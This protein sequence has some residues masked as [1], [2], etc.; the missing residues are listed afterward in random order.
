[1]SSDCERSGVWLSHRERKD[2]ESVNGQVRGKAEPAGVTQ[3]PG[4]L[5]LWR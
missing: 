2:D 5:V 3:N 4:F 1:M